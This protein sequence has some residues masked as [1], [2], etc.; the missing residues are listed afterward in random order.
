M[1]PMTILALVQLSIKVAGDL[2]KLAKEA[3]QPGRVVS[4]DEIAAV[5]M[6]LDSSQDNFEA[7]LAK[8][9]AEAAGD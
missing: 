3:Q 7:Q 8:M 6:Q 4:Q 9:E 2:S 5:L 1:D